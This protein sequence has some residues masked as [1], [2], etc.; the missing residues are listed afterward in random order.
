[1]EPY[2]KDA[3][4]WMWGHCIFLGN[5][6]HDGKHYDL[7][8]YVHNYGVSAAIV[9]SNTEGCYISGSLRDCVNSTD[10]PRHDMY[11]ETYKRYKEH[12]GES[13]GN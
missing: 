3:N 6:I 4:N 11:L 9:Y 7:G 2:W 1:M 13:R 10:S 5:Y 12:I 8:V